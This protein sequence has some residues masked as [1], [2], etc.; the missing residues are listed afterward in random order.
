MIDVSRFRDFQPAELFDGEP[1]LDTRTGDFDME[2]QGGSWD[3]DQL[4]GVEALYPQKTPDHLGILS[5]IASPDADAT[6]ARRR[7]PFVDRIGPNANPA[8]T[9][10]GLPP[11][12]GRPESELCGRSRL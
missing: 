8:A 10:I 12:L 3:F 11:L 6:A 4:E 7:Q 9:A 2:Y 5:L 1:S